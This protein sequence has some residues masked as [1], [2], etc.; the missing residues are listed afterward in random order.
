MQLSAQRGADLPVAMCFHTRFQSQSHNHRKSHDKRDSIWRRQVSIA[1]GGSSTK[2]EC[3]RRGRA[4]FSFC[5]TAIGNITATEGGPLLP[6]ASRN[7]RPTNNTPP[8][9][10]QQSPTLVP[11]HAQS[12]DPP[13]MVGEGTSKRHAGPCPTAV[14]RRAVLQS[15]R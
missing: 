13:V 5:S 2:T 4:P 11:Q 14:D 9:P 15:R 6:L 12:M 1:E 8:Q 3:S 10:Q 7:V